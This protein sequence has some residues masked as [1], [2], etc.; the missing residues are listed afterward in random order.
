MSGRLDRQGRRLLVAGAPLAWLV[1][2]FLA[3]FAIVLKISVSEPVT[4][5]PPYGPAIDWT[6]GV[7][8][9]L[10]AL[11]GFD[12]DSYRTLAGDDLYLAALLSSLRIA[13]VSTV[14]LVLA[15]YPIAYAMARAPPR[16]RPALL[17]AVI[18]P[19]WT[20]FLVRVYAWVAILR[21]EGLLNAALQGAGLITEPLQVL[22]TE[23]AIYIGAVYAY[24]PFMILPLYA[25]LV[26]QDAVLLEAAAD[27]GATPWAAF[28]RVTLPLSLP[29]LA[30]GSLLV[31]IPI[32]GE[33]VIPDLLGGSDTLMLG[34]VLWNEFFSNR[35]WPLA[36]AVAVVLLLL[37]VPPLLAAQR[38]RAMRGEGA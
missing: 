21:P 27:L 16:L 3:P 9:L 19:F 33:F 4:G 13:A 12:L 1:V 2:F 34:R 36:S 8:A 30:A 22:N 10:D 18:L 20:S 7:Q 24:L 11:P 37:I 31:F 38:L 17:L 28:R 14:L 23:A 25:V 6:G 35:D 5:R 29:G 15:G 32:L 26:Q